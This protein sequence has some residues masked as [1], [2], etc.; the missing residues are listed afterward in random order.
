[1]LILIPINNVKAGFFIYLNT[2]H[3]NLNLFYFS[4]NH[5]IHMNLNTSHV[6]L[7][8]PISIEIVTTI[9]DL[10]TSHVNLNL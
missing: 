2:S 5:L 1:M 7:N 10:N 9:A 8:L 3:V 6:N 4:S